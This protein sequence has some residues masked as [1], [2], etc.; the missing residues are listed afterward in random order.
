MWSGVSSLFINTVNGIKNTVSNVWSSI[1]GVT[2]TVWN[3]INLQ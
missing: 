2:T 1:L 3:N